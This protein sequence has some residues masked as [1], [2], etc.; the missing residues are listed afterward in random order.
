MFNLGKNSI[1]HLSTCHPKWVRICYRV[2][3]RYDYSII[4]GFRDEIEQ[5]IAFEEGNSNVVWPDSNHNRKPSTA[6]DAIPHPKGY[7]ASI[8]EFVHM[9]A[10]F[11]KAAEEEGIKI[12]WGGFFLKADGSLF[13]DAGHFELDESEFE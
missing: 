8:R 4:W 7:K 6:L 10:H 12:K 13:F 5:N 2:I 11:M 9:A 1:R 3:K